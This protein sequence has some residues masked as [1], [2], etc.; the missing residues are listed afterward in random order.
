M[1]HK[2]LIVVA[3]LLIIG[4]AVGAY[5]IG[6][7]K[8]LAPT[9]TKIV[10]PPIIYSYIRVNT[11]LPH[12]A[13]KSPLNISGQA[14]GSWY[15]EASAPVTLKNASGIVIASGHVTAQGDWMTTNFVPFTASLTF[16][17]QPANSV[18]TLLL[19]NDNPSGDPTKD[20]TLVIPVTF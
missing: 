2:A 11:P 9:E 13:I 20:K 7:K 15:F 14:V 6:T 19:K 3:I 1:S 5:T 10:E 8:S 16:P 18:G 4:I 12:T 17:P